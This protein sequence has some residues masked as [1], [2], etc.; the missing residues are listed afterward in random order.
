[1]INF[2]VFK[3][4]RVLVTG[5]TGFKGSWLCKILEM[6]GAEIFG[7][8]LE[9]QAGAQYR[10]LSIPIRNPESEIGNIIDYQTVSRVIQEADP[11]LVIHLAAQP[12]VLKSFRE[13]RETFETNIMGGVNLLESLR[14]KASS[15][16]ALVFATSDKA[17][18]N[19]EWEWGYRESDRIGGSD[20]YSASKGAVELVFSSYLRSFL[21]GSSTSAA[22]VRAGNV[23]GGGDWSEDRLVPDVIRSIRRREDVTIR[24]PNS[25]RP[26]QHVL[27]PLSGYLSLAESMLKRETSIAPA[28]NFGPA[29][30]SRK[31]VLELTEKLIM[32]QDVADIKVIET[33]SAAHEA[34]LLQLNC[35]RANRDLGWSPRWDFDTTIGKTGEWYLSEGR[36]ESVREL[37]ESQILQYFEELSN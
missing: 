32:T 36:G 12:L 22:T 37:T 3:G 31:T 23:I 10:S 26:W 16:R 14:T 30:Q 9:P 2:S 1:M 18:E 25:T 4:L 13:P 6:S 20:P 27:E 15:L 21:A 29:A 7:L 5:H 8:A 34:N 28:Y 19:V 33:E 17:Y 24:R 35:E 11:E